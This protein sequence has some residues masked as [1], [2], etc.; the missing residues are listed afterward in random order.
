ML[1]DMDELALSLT[2]TLTA[3]SGEETTGT[4]TFVS[5]A[6]EFNG[7]G[8]FTRINSSIDVAGGHGICLRRRKRRLTIWHSANES[9]SYTLEGSERGFI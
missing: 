6:R 4:V 9:E 1:F 3:E 7:T 2:L 5:S 8:L